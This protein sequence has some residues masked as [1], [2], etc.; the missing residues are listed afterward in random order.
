MHTISFPAV[1][2]RMVGLVPGAYM[3]A[4]VL[5][6]QNIPSRE[7]YQYVLFI[8]DHCSK[9]CWVFPLKTCDAGLIL[10]Y[11]EI[12]VRE[13]L[14]SLNIHL[15]HFHSDGGARSILPKTP[16]LFFIRAELL[17]PTLHVILLR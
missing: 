16:Y 14:P 17:L 15:K 4:D 6:M 10:K 5:S 3:S 12:F 11:L 7:G 13:I 8:V 2:D 1:R 9:M